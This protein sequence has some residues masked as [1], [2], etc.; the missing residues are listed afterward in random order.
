MTSNNGFGRNSRVNKVTVTYLTVA[1]VA[2]KYNQY[3]FKYYIVV[4]Q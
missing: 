2:I 4:I 3:Y 1:S